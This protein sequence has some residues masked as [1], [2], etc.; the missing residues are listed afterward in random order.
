[1]TTSGWLAYT[2]E[3]WYRKAIWA[4][5]RYQAQSTAGGIQD[6]QENLAAQS[7]PPDACAWLS[8]THENPRWTAGTK[9]T[10][11]SRTPSINREAQSCQKGE[12]ESLSVATTLAFTNIIRFSAVARRGA[13]VATISTQFEYYAE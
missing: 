1:L 10:T 8:P 13:Q 2:F 3:A 7:P 5:P 4:F 11:R 6:D 9:E 12:L